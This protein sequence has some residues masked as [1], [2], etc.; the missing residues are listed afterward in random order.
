MNISSYGK[1]VIPSLIVSKI[2]SSSSN[3][4]PLLR[5]FHRKKKINGQS[6]WNGI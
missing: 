4:I 2:L 6:M 1:F 5:L 3:P